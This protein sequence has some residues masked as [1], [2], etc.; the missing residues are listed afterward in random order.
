MYSCVGRNFQGLPHGNYPMQQGDLAA[1]QE[2]LLFFTETA[3]GSRPY[4]QK[5]NFFVTSNV[6]K[7]LGWTPRCAVSLYR[8]RIKKIPSLLQ[9]LA[10]AFV[11]RF[12]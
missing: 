12:D 3:W 8:H 10:Q 5:G 9:I 2:A 7:R 1:L 11:I 6:L 4:L